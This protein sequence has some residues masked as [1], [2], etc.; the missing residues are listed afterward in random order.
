MTRYALISVFNKTNISI[1]AS[2]LIKKGYKIV[3]TPGTGKVLKKNK[4]NFTPIAEVT[5]NPNAFKDCIQAISSSTAIGIL[6][7]RNSSVHKK[8]LNTLGLKQIDVVI[9]NFP[10]LHEVVKN[11]NDFNIRHVDVG[12]PFMTRSAAVNFKDVLVIIDINDYN[13][14]A[15]ALKNNSVDKV[16]RKQMAIKAFTYSYKY[17]LK[18]V[19]WLKSS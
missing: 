1:I 9:C 4:I 7:D 2:A 11:I 17:D 18:I 3:A 8:Q 14:V 13:K 10:P 19:E 12:G 16:F 6:F 5:H 15:K